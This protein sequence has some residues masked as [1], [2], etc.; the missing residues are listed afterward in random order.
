VSPINQKVL[1]QWAG[2]AAAASLLALCL[3]LLGS[4]AMAAEREPTLSQPAMGRADLSVPRSAAG[5]EQVNPG[6]TLDMFRGVIWGRVDPGDLVTVTRTAGGDAYASAEADGKGFFWAMPFDGLNP[7][8][9]ASI[10]GGDTFELYVN[11]GLAATVSPLNITGGI[12]V[13]ADQV[14]GHIDGAGAGI[15]VSVTVGALGQFASGPQATTATDGSGNFAVT[16][17]DIDLKARN[18]VAVD[19]NVGGNYVRNYLFPDPPV[20]VIEQYNH[21]AG[22]APPGQMVTAT[23]YLTY[24]TDVRWQY[25]ANANWPYGIYHIPEARADEDAQPG[26]VVEVEFEDQHHPARY[27]GSLLRR[28]SR[29]GVGHRA[30]GGDG[31]HQHVAADGQRPGLRRDHGCR[32]GGRHLPGCLFHR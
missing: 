18:L 31:A 20:F 32:R 1:K 8:W 5:I 21:V 30:P 24:P 11:G 10:H 23:A 12:N 6:F 19:Y 28:G 22:Y 7:G 15:P 14:A 13:L 3:I 2:L 29:P 4:Q 26:E 27:G 17:A 16:L 25:S 9:P